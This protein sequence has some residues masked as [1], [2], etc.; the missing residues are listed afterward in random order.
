MKKLRLSSS[1]RTPVLGLYR[2]LLR[3]SNILSQQNSPY[4][5]GRYS[6]QL[7]RTIRTQFRQNAKI[8]NESR[9]RRV[10][11]QA[12]LDELLLR[13]ASRAA[14][15][16]SLQQLHKRI[17]CELI[18]QTHKKFRFS[19]HS[20]R[21][22]EEE[23]SYSEKLRKQTIVDREQFFLKYLY[24]ELPDQEVVQLSLQRH[25]KRKEVRHLRKL[26]YRGFNP[27]VPTVRLIRGPMLY[28]IRMPAMPSRYTANLSR[29]VKLH[30]QELDFIPAVNQAI[31]YAVMQ[32]EW[33]FLLHISSLGYD[34]M[35]FQAELADLHRVVPKLSLSTAMSSKID[36]PFA[37]FVK[38]IKPL[39]S[40]QDNSDLLY[41]FL[42]DNTTYSKSHIEIAEYTCDL[43]RDRY[44]K[45][46]IYRQSM[47]RRAANLKYSFYR[48]SHD[49]QRRFAFSNLQAQ[50]ACLEA[51]L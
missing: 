25:E 12:Y 36:S 48:N 46:P 18:K 23:K 4:I 50:Q 35:E 22:P 49:F 21:T 32:D 27:F 5:T 47:T 39:A 30:Q 15:E 13:R 29:L 9:C 11:E 3:H 17:E 41:K 51:D 6:E 37:S 26:I 8:N 2:A 44:A 7:N 28:Y 33:E 10:L 45:R 16:K 42:K 1:H 38:I 14:D 31:D 24:P 20:I 40:K 34:P 19:S 43:F